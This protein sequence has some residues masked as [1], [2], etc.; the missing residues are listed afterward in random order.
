VITAIRVLKDKIIVT[1]VFLILWQIVLSQKDEQ[2]QV[3][4]LNSNNTSFPDSAR[5]HGY[6]YD[7]TFYSVN[8]HY[9]DNSVLL[10]I[11]RRLHRKGRIDLIFWFHGWH[12]NIDTA[13]KFYE[14]EKQFIDSKRNAILVMAETAKNAPDSY[15]GKLENP[16]VFKTLVKDVMTNLKEH[17]IVKQK[18]EPGNIVL[19]GHSGAYRI[20]AFILEKGKIAVEEVYLF[21]A[22]YGQTDKFMSWIQQD[23]GHHFVNLY[24]NHGGGTDEVSIEMMRQLGDHSLPYTLIEEQSLNPINVKASR[25]LFVHSMR[26]HNVVINRPDNLKLFL[27]NSF[28]LKPLLK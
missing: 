15:G 12:N 10:I 13:M 9:N 16:G 5:G 6:S 2:V 25:I 28:V 7:S 18:S 20:I 1:S 3:L 21:D 17:G 14:I 23:K 24:T 27:E 8:E 19:A 26:E 4:R 11:P 22:L